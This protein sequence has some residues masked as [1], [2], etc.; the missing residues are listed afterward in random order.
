MSMRIVF[1]DRSILKGDIVFG[2]AER[3]RSI[4]DLGYTVE[5]P[6]DRLWTEI[7]N[8][9]GASVVKV[10][11][12]SLR[13]DKAVVNGKEMKMKEWMADWKNLYVLS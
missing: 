7:R 8:A 11:H 2:E 1:P 13:S 3:A 9:E 4:G 6:P 10:E 12:H 5:S